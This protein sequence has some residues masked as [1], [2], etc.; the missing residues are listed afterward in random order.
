[1]KA[2]LYLLKY[3]N[4]IIAKPLDEASNCGARSRIYYN[5]NIDIMT[6]QFLTHMQHTGIKTASQ[7]CFGFVCC[8]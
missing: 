7:H 5:F 3:N 2:N 4:I 1:M 6:L 8:L